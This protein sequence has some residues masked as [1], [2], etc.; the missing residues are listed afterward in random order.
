MKLVKPVSTPL[1]THFKLSKRACPTT[2][3][4]R[5]SSIPYSFVG[6]S[7]MYA[8]VCTKPDITRAF[9]LCVDFYRIQ[10]RLTGK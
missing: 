1:A 4:E 6:C 9:G 7:L 10:V 3:K 2:K 5:M 8:I